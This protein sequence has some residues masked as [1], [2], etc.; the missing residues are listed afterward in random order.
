MENII[1]NW[2]SE[3]QKAHASILRDLLI[4][5]FIRNP[6]GL[7]FKGGTAISF[8]YG[9][10]RFSQDIDLSSPDMDCYAIIDDV[11]E[12]L[13]KDYNY[14]I[15]N[16]WENEIYQQP[17]FR[18]YFLAFKY[19]L[20]DSINATLDYSIGNC[21]LAP[22]KKDLANDYRATKIDVMQPEEILAEKI[23][24]IYSRQKGRDLYDL[25]HLSVSRRTRISKAVIAAKFKES[26]DLK[27]KKYSFGS[28]K[29]RVEALKP[30]WA[31]LDGIVNNFSPESFDTIKG[32]VLDTFKTV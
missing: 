17:R 3:K 21:I 6:N 10:D 13:E 20:S 15:V 5:I 1:K 4:E 9:G 25:Y 32:A 12:S 16:E 14:E 18:R 8:F 31:D 19:G 26:V 7:V 30:Y 2:F 28:F 22:E 27:G 23:L 11:L 29:D 24:A